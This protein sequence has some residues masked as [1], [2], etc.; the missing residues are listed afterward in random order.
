MTDHYEDIYLN[1]AEQYEKMVS[2]EDYEHNIEASIKKVIDL[3]GLDVIDSGAG[4]GRLACMYAGIV[5]SMAVFDT[6]KAML[7]VAEARLI[8]SG[9]TNWRIDVADHRKLP[10]ADNSADVILT[11]WSLVYTVVWHQENWREELGRALAEMK[12]VLRPGGTIIIFETMGTGFEE[13][14]PPADLLD[15]FKYLEEDGFSSYWF[16]TD[17]RFKSVEEAKQLTS[18][19][20]GD[21]MMQKVKVSHSVILPECTGMWWKKLE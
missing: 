8:E 19:F 18:F 16:R 4:T 20:F 2:R 5:R 9:L 13:P 1:K 7:D 15:Y 3:T 11:G 14:N 21:E 17:Y 10:A 6:S 12:R